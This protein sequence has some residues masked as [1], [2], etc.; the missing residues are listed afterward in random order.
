LVTTKIV[1]VGCTCPG[2]FLKEYKAYKAQEGVLIC[3]NRGSTSILHKL[4]IL[5]AYETYFALV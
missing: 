2:L 4:D 5:K 1:S 3:A